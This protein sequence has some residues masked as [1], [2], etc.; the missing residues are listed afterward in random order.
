VPFFKL[1]VFTRR[2]K[3]GFKHYRLSGVLPAGT[4]ALNGY[5]AN[6]NI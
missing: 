2:L 4:R 3:L 1:Q 5:K 6:L